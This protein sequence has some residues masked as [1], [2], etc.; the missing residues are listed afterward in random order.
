MP[1]PY[2]T[3]MSS[4][5]TVFKP[6][7]AADAITQ[8]QYPIALDHDVRIIE[9]LL[10]VDRAEEAPAGAEDHRHDVHRHLVDQA[11]RL[12]ADVAGRHADRAIS[13]EF[14]ALGDRLPHIADEVVRRLRV[15]PVRLRPVRH[16]DHVGAGRWYAFPAVGDV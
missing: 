13:G 10:A 3:E 16:D 1:K 2:C 11:E 9:Q 8:V 14:L 5:D 7:S 4:S 12:A 6:G 15:P